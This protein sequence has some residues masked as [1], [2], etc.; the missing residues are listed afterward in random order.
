M[1][2]SNKDG[3]KRK[4]YCRGNNVWQIII[5]SLIGNDSRK[6]RVKGDN[7]G[8][9]NRDLLFIL[10]NDY[11]T[12]MIDMD[13]KLHKF[14][15]SEAKELVVHKI[16]YDKMF[17][18]YGKE[19]VML[20]N[21]VKYCPELYEMNII[22]KVYGEIN[23]WKHDSHRPIQ[24]ITTLVLERYK[25]E[26]V[27]NIIEPYLLIRG[28]HLNEPKKRC[29]PTVT[30][31]TTIKSAVNQPE[32]T[33]NVVAAPVS[34]LLPK[35]LV[36]GKEYEKEDNDDNCLERKTDSGERQITPLQK[37]MTQKVKKYISNCSI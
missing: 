10:V 5:R 22:H 32:I 36:N 34:S 31:D 35:M 19:L 21:K 27:K 29:L 24:L 18:R 30:Q 3:T 7:A 12:Q 16:I 28:S 6:L 2:L 33:T 25:S 14:R 23:Q 20:W 1:P 26:I 37:D 13:R 15:R 11:L 17:K 8:A 9:Y 4:L